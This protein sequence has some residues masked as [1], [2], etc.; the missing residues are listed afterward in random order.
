MRTFARTRARVGLAP[1]QRLC[2][3]LNRAFPRVPQPL[4]SVKERPRLTAISPTA[5]LSLT[6]RLWTSKASCEFDLGSFNDG[7]YYAAIEEKERS[8]P[9]TSVLY[10]CDN[11]SEGKELRLRQQY[12][13]VSATLQ[14]ILRRY[15]KRPRPWVDLP[16][17][18]AIQVRSDPIRSFSRRMSTPD[19][20]REMY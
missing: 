5:S 17:K 8:E 4:P 2:E 14:D 1:R 13:Y 9:L 10:P 15:K 6:L 12:F 7:Q 3:S 16:A 18:V 20:S 19:R 11:N